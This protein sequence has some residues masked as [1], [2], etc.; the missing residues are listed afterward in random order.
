MNPER[1]LTGIDSFAVA[2]IITSL[3][4]GPVS[5]S[6]LIERDAERFVLRIDNS[7]AGAL[8]LDRKAESEILALVGQS[9]IGPVQE[10]A[11]PERGISIM[12]YVEGRAWTA[13]DLQDVS[14]IE[15]LAM[16]LRE[17]HALEPCGRVLDINEK[18]DVYARIVNTHEGDG[19][20][21]SVR[22][23]LHDLKEPSAPVCLCHNDLSSANIIEGEVLAFIDWEYAAIGHP[24]F[25]LATIAQ[26]HRFDRFRT[27]VLLDAYFG[28]MHAED[29][30]RF[31][32]FRSLYRHLLVLWLASVDR[33]CGINAQQRELLREE[34][35]ALQAGEP[36]VK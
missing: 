25:D 28:A 4:G 21:D 13:S 18:V 31:E 10:F 22:R 11:D 2:R 12:R 7:V 23:I 5:D 33:L 34:R 19:L 16:R 26:H 20:S 24:M 32:R 6:Y 27:G 29:Q 8:A 3:P 15:A 17:L 14:H 35:A 9:G 30:E 36:G 1:I